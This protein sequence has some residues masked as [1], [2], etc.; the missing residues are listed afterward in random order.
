MK[1]KS[2]GLALIITM[3]MVLTACTNSSPQKTAQKYL[4]ALVAGDVKTLENCKLPLSQSISSVSKEAARGI[5]NWMFD[6]DFSGDSMDATSGVLLSYVFFGY[7]F[8]VTDAE[9]DGKKAKVFFDIYIDD[10]LSSSKEYLPLT[11]YNGDWYVDFTGYL[12]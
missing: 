9:I 7:D 8:K 3:A 4:N 10:I 11:Q 6:I 5:T 1:K 2:I 12:D